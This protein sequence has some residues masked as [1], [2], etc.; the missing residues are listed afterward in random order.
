MRQLMR[1]CER[2]RERDCERELIPKSI[3]FVKDKF[4]LQHYSVQGHRIFRRLHI[5]R[6]NKR[7]GFP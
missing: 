1:E 6:F 7:Y 4:T 3:L 5:F 2:E